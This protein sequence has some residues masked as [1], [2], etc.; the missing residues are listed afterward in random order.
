MKRVLFF[1]CVLI[2]ANTVFA[3]VR[4]P[5][6]F[7]DNM[8]LQRDHPIPVWG[9]AD[10]GEKVTVQL[11]DEIVKAK[12]GKDGKWKVQ[13]KQQS[14]GGPFTLTVSGKNQVIIKNVLI[15]EV[16][17]CSGQ[18]NME[19][20]VSRSGDRYAKEMREANND[21]IRH[22]KVPRT[23]SDTPATDI[24]AADWKI[25]ND[26]ANVAQFTSVGYFFA[27]KLYE[28]LKVPV[29][30]INSSWGGTAVETW[31]SRPSFDSAEEF[32]GAVTKTFEQ[33]KA[34]A[35]NGEVQPNMYPSLLFNGMINP[36]IPY[37]IKGALWYQ[38]ETNAGR[39]AQYKKAFPLMIT[40]WR[41][42]W[43]EGDFPFYFVQ[44][45]S[46]IADSGTSAH[47]SSWAELREAQTSTLSLP[48]T[49]MAVTL[50]IGETN[51][52][53]PTNK[54]DVGLRLAAIALSQLYGR[55]TEY[56]GPVYDTMT[57]EGNKITI[58]F[59]HAQNGLWVKDKYNYL[60]GFEVA[61]NDQKFYYAKAEV[62]DGKVIVYSD[63]VSA[64]VAV[65]YGWAND[66][67]EA[68]L[69][70]REGFPAVPFR[71]DKWKGITEGV[72]FE[73]KGSGE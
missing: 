45:A 19:M 13:L 54:K 36:L 73:V 7:G 38:G 58:S 46:Y 37:A 60:K 21:Q 61:G 47:G 48:N 50:D 26:S 53:H 27:K 41:T 44:L 32:R 43:K 71:S 1:A 16:W 20:P 15:G 40:D 39:A 49:G 51:D 3:D 24:N 30:L 10:P 72:R 34:T 35:T 55:K 11:Q 56:S 69:Y 6:I 18:S 25:A 63:S 57:I 23:I 14:A 65:R 70:N 33:I 52:I 4:L 29:G 66:M 5:K 22:I 17:L 59:T 12:A 31:I 2:I 28:E 9:W 8:V 68:D 67:P 42:K 62:K 64:P